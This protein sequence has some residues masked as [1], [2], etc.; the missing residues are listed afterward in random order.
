MVT[1]VQVFSGAG[2]AMVNVMHLLIPIR[3]DAA[4]F[5]GILR[6][7]MKCGTLFMSLMPL[8]RLFITLMSPAYPDLYPF[9]G[10]Y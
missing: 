2:S 7:N 4:L 10:T 8:K 5:Q 1:Q 6:Y 9:T 3:R